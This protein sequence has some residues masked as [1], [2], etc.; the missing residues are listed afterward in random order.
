MGV[1]IGQDADDRLQLLLL[2]PELLRALLVGPEFGLFE[3]LRYFGETRLL[4]VEVKDT[5]AAR[6]S[7]GRGPKASRRGR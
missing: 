7:G 6:P 3:F 1:E 5:S 2:A 4:R